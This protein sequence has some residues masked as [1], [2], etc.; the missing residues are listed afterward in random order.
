[1]KNIFKNFLLGAATVGVM[2]SCNDF[3][4]QSSPSELTEENVFNSIYYANNVLNKVYG[5]LTLDQ[6]Y[7][8]Y[9]GFVWHLNSD[10]ELVDGLGTNAINASS[11]RGN[12]NY[13]QNSGWANLARAWDNMFSVI[14]YANIVVHG[15]TNSSLLGE[16]A[17]TVRQALQIK[18][19][20]QTLRAMVYLDMI[21]NF[22]D[23]PMKMEPSKS[24]LSNAYLSK[25]DRDDILD[26]LIEDLEDAIPN[27]PWAGAV[28][29]EHVT[30]GYAHSLLANIAL[31]RAGWAIR[32]SAK[33][34]YETATITD[35]T[36]PTQRPGQEE[37]TALYN[38]AL[39]HLTEVIT[40]GRH[41]LNPSIA[42][43]W[44]LVNQLELDQTYKENIFEIPMGLGRS[45]EL[46]YT[47]GVRINGS[48]TLYGEKGNSSG[49]V[50]LAA[51]YFWSF[52]RNDLRRDLTCAPYVLKETDGVVVESFDGNKPFEMYVAKWDIRKMSDKWRE[53][54]IATGNAKWMSG[55]NVTKMR[56]SYVLLVDAEVINELYGPDV[57][58]SAGMTAR[59]ALGL[60]HTRA[61]AA[62]D[63]AAAQTYIDNIPGSQQAFF[64]AIVDE[65]A[66]EL[67]G[68]GY[69]KYDLLR[70][71]LLGTKL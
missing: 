39:T 7:S 71:N 6:T 52:D 61:F 31:T 19:E 45:G 12:M 32:E 47:V 38:K 68:E 4:N 15:I 17:S 66:W 30:R 54:A 59:Q 42:N 63:K 40:S 67:A 21:R 11:E 24:D 8:Q 1:M 41:Q 43:H 29:T 35:P 27:L 10:Y 44:Y 69:R 70:W 55:I 46:G 48:S 28:T 16:D 18:A 14:E 50:K 25:T 64:N 65:N 58:G 53:T 23:M 22:G 56:Y 60:V 3:L 33:A 2:T 51:P 49:K 36:Y 26:F 13:N 20:A 62:E 57:N 9:F 37:R 5:E 34:G